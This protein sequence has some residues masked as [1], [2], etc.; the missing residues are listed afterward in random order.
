MKTEIVKITPEKALQI[1]KHNTKNVPLNNK[2]IEFYASEMIRGKWQL[3][4][5]GISIADDGTLI[6]GQH[7]LRAIVKSKV[8]VQMLVISELSFA[9][10]FNYYDTGRKRT[11][12]NVMG[13]AGIKNYGAIAAVVGKYLAMSKIKSMTES[14]R[15][16]EIGITNDDVIETYYKN[17]ELYQEIHSHCNINYSKIRLM[18]QSTSGGIMAYLI[19]DKKHDKQKVFRFF[20]QL[21]DGKVTDNNSIDLLRDQLIRSITTN[22]VLIPNVKMNLIAKAWNNYITGKIVKQLKFT[23]SSEYDIDFI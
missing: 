3:T 7:R 21:H 14:V 6:D 20:T 9:D 22:Y 15:H 19:I 18:T 23:Q 5:Q 16:R 11:A 13:A 2:L 10:T 12:G 1:L 8:S 17:P 4:G